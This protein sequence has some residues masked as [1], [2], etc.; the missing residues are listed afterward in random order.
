MLQELVISSLGLRVAFAFKVFTAAVGVALVVLSVGYFANEFEYLSRTGLPGLSDTILIVAVLG[1]FLSGVALMAE[2]PNSM[3]IRFRRLPRTH[4]TEQVYGFGTVL[5]IGLG[6]TLGSPLFILIPLNIVQYEIVSVSSLLVAAILSLL[7][8]RIYSKLYVILKKNNLESVG[9]PSFP[10]VAAGK[11]SV[12]YF[13]S[14]LSMAVANT[15]LAA[16]SA[17][18]FVLFSFEVMPSLLSDF[19]ITGIA[20]ELLVYLVIGIFV[21]WFIL[22]SVFESRFAKL[23][24]RFQVVL[25]FVMILI[26][27][28]QSSLL[29]TASSWNLTGL[30]NISNVAGGNILYA[31]LT[32]T[33]YLYLLFF[34]FQE[35]Q[36]LERE[37][38]DITRIPVLSWIKRSFSLSKISYLGIA[39]IISV[40][41]AAVV[42]I[43][44]ALA[45]YS[46][47][48]NLGL[49]ASSN[50]PALYIAKT[51]LGSGPEALMVVAFLIATL[52]TFV[53]SFL[54]ASRHLS[55][56]AEDGFMPHSVSKV[57]WVF[58]LASIGILAVAGQDFLVNIT[59]FMVLV[60]LGMIALSGVWIRKTRK[61][62]VERADALYVVVGAS[63]LVAAAAVYLF[64]PSV[65]VFGSLAIVITY[66]LFDIF[67][68]GALGI[69]L[70]LGVFDVTLYVLLSSYPHVFFSQ[71][72]FLFQWFKLP[73]ITTGILSELLL[74]S[75]LLMLINLAVNLRLQR[76]HSQKR[77]TLASKLLS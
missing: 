59:D 18:V 22:N 77:P 72:F 2:L 69:Q 33:S 21:G 23:I 44:Y 60:S 37:A 58:V 3:R 40:I 35:I 10:R 76:R 54:A 52:T 75:S 42:N 4:T 25:T 65:A 13:V 70:F 61:S 8:A 15:A 12:R 20:S 57:S 27:V 11:R 31:L 5:A 66:L 34:G 32:N 7:T 16:Y 73:S 6:A 64:S 63:C 36:A 55:S 71:N 67:E 14:R 19:G 41:V 48:P 1:A 50:I 39:M 24:G 68:L 29:G 46:T 74:V 56:L 43:F 17:I 38:L 62:V 49:L 28:Y 26:L 30:F 51:V 47:H 45:V 9:G 53:P